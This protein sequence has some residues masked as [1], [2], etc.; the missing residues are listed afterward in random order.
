M[1][2]FSLAILAV[3][4][5]YISRCTAPLKPDRRIPYNL[6][7]PVSKF[8]LQNSLK[9]V[10]GLSVTADNEVA[11]IEDEQ[12]K[13]FFYDLDEKRVIRKVSFKN[14]GDFEDLK[15][16]GD[17]AFAL[18]SDGTLFELTH[19]QDQNQAVIEHEYNTGLT[20]ENNTEG[21]CYDATRKQ[22]LIACKNKAEISG[23]KKGER[24]IYCF[25]PVKGSVPDTP[26]YRISLREVNHIAY[27][28]AHTAILK[29]MHFYRHTKS[30]SFEPSGIAI[31]PFTGD[32]YILSSVGDLLV[33]LNKNGKIKNAIRL[34]PKV[35]KQPEGIDFDAAGNLFISNEGRRGRGNILKFSYIKK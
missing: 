32:L 29:F 30:V 34:S 17:T 18:R 16:H 9:E 23:K 2:S 31:Q 15:V 10:S 26:C 8:V 22:Y 27:G 20:K 1:F 28:F 25:D 11:L 7:E 24:A 14:K 6:K 21:L 4:A 13:I 12:G 3:F 33:I 5:T 19:L 35:F